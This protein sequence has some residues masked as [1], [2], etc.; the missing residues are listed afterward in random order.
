[1]DNQTIEEIYKHLNDAEKY[2]DA[3][4]WYR[5]KKQISLVRLLLE[6]L[7]ENQSQVDSLPLSAEDF[8]KRNYDAAG[9]VEFKG[10]AE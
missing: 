7:T 9:V 5:A 3:S 2:I 6:D 10:S 4:M 1:M 8:I